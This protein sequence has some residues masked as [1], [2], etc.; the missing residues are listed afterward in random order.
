M[1]ICHMVLNELPN[2]VASKPQRGD[3][4]YLIDNYLDKRYLCVYQGP[5]DDPYSHL[6]S[7]EFAAD[8]YMKEIDKLKVE[9]TKMDKRCDNCKHWHYGGLGANISFCKHDDQ[10]GI[11]VPKFTCCDKHEPKEKKSTPFDGIK[12]YLKDTST[13]ELAIKYVCEDCGKLMDEPG[14]WWLALAL[15]DING[16]QTRPTGYHYRCEECD[17]KKDGKI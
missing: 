10:V 16:K 9:E 14:N 4:A 15:R 8:F 11:V 17:K 7:E 13:G 6:I 1:N 12:F 5:D 2:W 3:V